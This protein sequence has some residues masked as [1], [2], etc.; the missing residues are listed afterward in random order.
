MDAGAMVSLAEQWTNV[1]TQR[2]CKSQEINED[3]QIDSSYGY[4][5]SVS[6]DVNGCAGTLNEVRFL[7]HVQC[8]CSS[9]SRMNTLIRTLLSQQI[10]VIKN[11]LLVQYTAI[12]FYFELDSVSLR[13]FPRGN[14]RLLLTSPMGTTSTLLFE[15]PRDV[16][17]SNF[18]DWPFLSVH[19]WGEKAEGRWTLQVINAGS[20]HV[21]SP[22]KSN[23]DKEQSAP[24]PYILFLLYTDFLSVFRMIF[25]ERISSF[26]DMPRRTFF[27]PITQLFFER[28]FAW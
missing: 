21:N 14:L 4:T 28:H 27:E 25:P 18:D 13:F 20:R 15:R 12:G 6:M 17:N 3:R 10:N 1:P 5:L 24:S 22:G 7:E 19:F 9:S 23:F 16:L 8:K 2:I 26:S 11:N